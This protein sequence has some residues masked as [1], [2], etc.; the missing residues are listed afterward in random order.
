[1]QTPGRKGLAVADRRSHLLLWVTV[2]LGLALDLATKSLGWAFLGGPPE[3]GGREIAV[4]P[5]WLRLF[6]SR[7]PGIVFGFNFSESFGIGATGGRLLTVLLTLLTSALIFYI[8]AASRPRQRW[9]HLAC[10]LILAGALGNL[11]DRLLFGFVR[12]IIQITAHAT[13]GGMTL[14]WPYV[15]NVADAYLVVGVIVVAIVFMFARPTGADGAQAKT[16]K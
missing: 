10:G 1:M 14:Q 7:N 15:F 6:A 12:D 4:I 11:Y 9:L 5:E 16:R 3:S 13:I 8:F 2:G